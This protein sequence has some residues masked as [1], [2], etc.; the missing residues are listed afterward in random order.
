MLKCLRCHVEL[1]RK[2][3]G[4]IPGAPLAVFSVPSTGEVPTDGGWLCA[5]CAWHD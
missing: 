3:E 5:T 4:P 2:D 1:I